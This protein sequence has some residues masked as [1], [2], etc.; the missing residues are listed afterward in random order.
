MYKFICLYFW[1]YD[2]PYPRVDFTIQFALGFEQ[3]T[4]NEK[5]FAFQITEQAFITLNWVP[6]V[7]QPLCL[8]HIDLS[9]LYEEISI[10]RDRSKA[11]VLAAS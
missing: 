6:I 2:L 10:L 3:I 5:S 7:L 4:E 9:L 1:Y 11:A 8:S